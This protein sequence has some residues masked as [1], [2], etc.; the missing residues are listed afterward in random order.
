MQHD[1]LSSFLSSSLNVELVYILLSSI[2]TF[3]SKE[4][5][6]DKKNII[7]HE[8]RSEDNKK[9]LKLDFNRYDLNNL[10]V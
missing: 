7:V 6:L 3:L 10:N 9:V 4:S 1:A 8:I 2:T 5:Q